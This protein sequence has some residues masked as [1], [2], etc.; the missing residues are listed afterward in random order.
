MWWCGAPQ[1]PARV[2]CVQTGIAGVAMGTDDWVTKQK[3]Q[4]IDWPKP[5]KWTAEW[6]G[7]NYTPREGQEPTL[8]ARVVS[9]WLFGVKWRKRG[10]GDGV[11]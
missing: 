2:R 7:L 10:G 9:R 6:I 3:V 8:L 5:G 11:A 4:V 1:T